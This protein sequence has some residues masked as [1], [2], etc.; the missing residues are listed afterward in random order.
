MLVVFGPAYKLF[1][2]E[3]RSLDW[4]F[5][6]CGFVGKAAI[7]GTLVVGIGW[8]FSVSD[9]GHPAIQLL[10]QTSLCSW[11]MVAIKGMLGEAK[12]DGITLVLL[13][14]KTVLGDYHGEERHC[15][16]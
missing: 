12:T 15:L 13:L 2:S 5:R 1:D 7:A 4:L 6:W 16:M 11:L 8:V 9:G 3:R 14:K 10:R